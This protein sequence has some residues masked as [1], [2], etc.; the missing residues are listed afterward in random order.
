VGLV[1]CDLCHHRDVHVAD[2]PPEADRLSWLEPR[3]RGVLGAR[4]HTD[5]GTRALFSSDASN[6]RVLPALVA[7]PQTIDQ[8][9]AVTQL[10]HEG[11]VAMT[12][13]GGGTSIAGNSLGAGVLIDT[14]SL[15]R[16][17]ELDPV[18][19]T[20]VVEPGV[21]LD[22]LNR[23]AAAHG[24]RVGPDP[25]THSRCTIGGMVG[26]NACGS[27]SVRWGT[28][29]DNTLGLDVI[30]ADGSRLRAASPE[31]ALREG[32]DAMVAANAELLRREL[33]PWPRRVSGYALDWL[34]PE[35]GTDVA[36]SLVGTEGGCVIVAAATIR[37]V[38]PP[39][40]RCL[41]VL[42]FEDDVAAAEAVPALLTE[43]PY[44][45]ESLTSE[46]LAL[47]PAAATGELLPSGGAWLLVEAG[48]ESAGDAREH[49]VRLAT[50]VGRSVGESSVRLLDSIG[51][52]AQLWRVRED[53]AGLASRLPDGRPAWPGFEDAAV[54]PDR[55]GAYLAQLHRLL[56]D[57][58]LEGV[59]YGHFGEGC[60]H[61][62]VGFGLDRPGGSE[63]YE[64]FMTAAAGLVV[65]HG[66]SLSGEHGDGRMRGPLLSRQFSPQL[67]DVF[68]QYKE[69]WDPDG[70]LNPGIIVDPPPLTEALR[71]VSPTVIT[72]RPDLA[73]HADGGD[74]RASVSRCIGIGKCVSQQG[75]AQMCPSFRASGDERHS[76]RG[77]ARLLQE[78]MAGSLSDDG[79]RSKDVVEA[80]DLCL[81]CKGCLSDCP[82]SVD[83]ASYKSEFLSH[84]YRHRLRPRS[85]Y[86]LGWL[87]V[88]LRLAERMPRVA[89]ATTRSRL[90][91][92][93]FA[94]SAGIASERSIPPIARRSFVRGYR[95]AAPVAKAPEASNGRVVLWP[96]TF[97]NH[98][99]PDVAHAAVRVLSAA[100]FDVNVPGAWVCCGLTWTTTGQLGTARRVLLRTLA[101]PELAGDDPVVVLEP[102][103]AASLRT[104]LTELLPG[105]PRAAS[106][107]K[108]VVTLAGILDRVGFQL[109]DRSSREAAGATAASAPTAV[110]T[111]AAVMQPHCH[112]QAVLGT[113]ADQRV[114][115]RNG[116]TV[117]TT[118]TGCCGLAGNFGAE[119]GH[120]TMS[121]AVAELSLVPA[122]RTA[123]PDALLLADGFSCR[124]QIES[125]AGR[126]A[127][128]LAELLAARLPALPEEAGTPAP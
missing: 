68:R 99:T 55:L 37:L 14:R 63:R 128:H 69:L 78:M 88:W 103:C 102:S 107:A 53:G 97:N 110:T 96:D 100:G 105:D 121:R 123:E 16:I 115:A 13:R 75:T 101:V 112:Q 34:L 25:S 51:A 23:A 120:E 33:P 5:L 15:A 11:R 60:I 31:G 91:R 81:S 125:L 62:R 36:R 70:L 71:S 64:R 38:R 8:L 119:R 1:A 87:P 67:L 22:D 108:R 111:S 6:Y 92:R 104:D 54:P 86:S 32:I 44:T 35:R 74:F 26:N 113:S 50:A 77:R 126:R 3:V 28:T 43:S 72:T 58:Q 61:L 48:G 30:R 109:S 10:C 4:V 89:N 66:G 52:Q 122:L 17:L 83:M 65:A 84:H 7:S 27:R 59:T 40:A 94:L 114:M 42:A 18:A 73:F 45:V 106:L 41:L 93:L 116:I 117:A 46:L 29:A 98:L 49:A 76:T 80:L 56:T 57:H 47:T 20:A 82:T 12:M 124:T 39:G 85:H 90:T 19:G 118:L 95:A 127:M 24:W 2:R 79:W 9:V 21:V